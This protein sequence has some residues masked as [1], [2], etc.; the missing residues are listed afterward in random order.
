MSFSAYATLSNPKAQPWQEAY[1][2]KPMQ[3]SWRADAKTFD[4]R[5]KLTN[6]EVAERISA[7]IYELPAKRLAKAAG[8]SK[9]TAQNAKR[10]YNSMSLAH[11]FNA[12]RDVPELHE[13]A[14]EMLGIS[15]SEAEFYSKIRTMMME[16]KR[17]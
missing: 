15:Q 2:A 10:G 6:R 3:K 11:F 8:S 14:L 7:R 9:Q 12:C 17:S 13:L 5:G 1:G 4:E 16:R